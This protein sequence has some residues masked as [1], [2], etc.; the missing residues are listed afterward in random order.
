[1]SPKGLGANAPSLM[2]IFR[3]RLIEASGEYKV[4]TT[5]QLGDSLIAFLND[6]G[7]KSVVLGGSPLSS[8]VGELLKGKVDILADFSN[9]DIDRKEA[10]KLCSR[11]DAGITGVDALIATT[12]TLAIASRNQGD[13]LC[14]SLP[15]IHLALA[16]QTPI[17]S[18]LETYMKYMDADLTLAFITG[19][20][21]TADIEKQLVLGAHGPTR[22]VVWGLDE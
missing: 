3:D 19:P 1:M 17:F 10:I 14:S 16:T 4:T 9:D 2:S 5:E 7:I 20:S 8:K 12:G 15:P 21:R 11:A 18:D 22:V 13:R 6:N